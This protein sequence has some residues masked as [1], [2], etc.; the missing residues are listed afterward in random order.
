MM[1]SQSPEPTA[2]TPSLN[3]RLLRDVHVTDGFHSLFTFFLFLQQFAFAFSPG[4]DKFT[5]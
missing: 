3:K 2:I 4:S 5:L 1:F